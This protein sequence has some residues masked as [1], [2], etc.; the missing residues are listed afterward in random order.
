LTERF[1]AR[2][3]ASV[4]GI[5]PVSIAPFSAFWTIKAYLPSGDVVSSATTYVFGQS[6][7]TADAHVMNK[8]SAL[9]SNRWASMDEIM[10]N[11]VTR[12]EQDRF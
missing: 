8:S 10:G 12:C 4:P 3:T 5:G 2:N 9:T 1:V 7:A 6:I 11:R